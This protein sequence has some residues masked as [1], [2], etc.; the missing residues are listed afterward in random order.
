MNCPIHNEPLTENL[1]GEMT[2]VQCDAEREARHRA[3]D[4][5]ARGLEDV[6]GVTVVTVGDGMDE[7]EFAEGDDD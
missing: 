4:E 3:G 7:G 2:C 5:F 1:L 6:Y